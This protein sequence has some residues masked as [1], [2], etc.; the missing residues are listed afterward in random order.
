MT[1]KRRSKCQLCGT[2]H[3]PKRRSSISDTPYTNKQKDGKSPPKTASKSMVPG[4][5]PPKHEQRNSTDE[6]ASHPASS[7]SQLSEGTGN[8]QTMTRLIATFT[9]CFETKTRENNI[10]Q[11]THLILVPPSLKEPPK[12]QDASSII[13]LTSSTMQTKTAD[14][15]APPP[16]NV[17]HSTPKK[18]QKKSQSGPPDEK[19]VT[20]SIPKEITI[21]ASDTLSTPVAM[22]HSQGRPTAS[23]T[24]NNDA[25]KLH[26]NRENHISLES[27]LSHMEDKLNHLLKVQR[28]IF[29]S[30]MA[31]PTCKDPPDYTPNFRSI[32]RA[33]IDLCESTSRIESHLKIA[34]PN[35][36]SHSPNDESNTD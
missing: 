20:N 2:R 18:A 33:L 32:T 8:V 21:A 10:G 27:R 7:R 13:D 14:K 9:P 19:S 29:Q 34:P 15:C 26:V 16:A 24:A 12:K 17:S 31:S 25:P 4:D 11:Q 28:L 6:A 23:I 22:P 30:T 3:C 35:I 36:S 5:N 1:K